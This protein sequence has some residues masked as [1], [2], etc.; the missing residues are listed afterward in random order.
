LQGFHIAHR[1]IYLL[2]LS[3]NLLIIFFKSS[4]EVLSSVEIEMKEGLTI[5]T[6]SVALTD[7]T[8]YILLGLKP[9]VPPPCYIHRGGGGSPKRYGTG[10]L[11]CVIAK[12]NKKDKKP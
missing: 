5:V 2:I 7:L 8:M 6:R 3:T 11:Q 9:R 1:I 4:K 12:C 10:P